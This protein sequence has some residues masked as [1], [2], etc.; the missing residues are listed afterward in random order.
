MPI[1]T[2]LQQNDTGIG[3][4]IT[5]V[6]N[7]GSTPVDL[8]NSSSQTIYIYRPDSIL[9]TYVASFV[10]NGSDGKIQC[11]TDITD[12]N[13]TGLYKVQAKYI[14]A[15]NVKHSEKGNFLVEPNLTGVN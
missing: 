7:D 3:I 9:L 14:I 4:T 10:T 15:G 8:S 13:I 6:Q 2:F 12:L 5:I 1:D 11:V